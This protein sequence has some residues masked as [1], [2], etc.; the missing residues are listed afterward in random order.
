MIVVRFKQ[1]Y[2][3]SVN[4]NSGLNIEFS[5]LIYWWIIGILV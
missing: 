5:L 4:G 2:S 1:Q 3:V